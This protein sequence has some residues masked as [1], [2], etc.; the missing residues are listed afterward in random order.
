[1]A[2]RTGALPDA[3]GEAA[4]APVSAQDQAAIAA[5]LVAAERRTAERWAKAL[6]RDR[7]AE[8]AAWRDLVWA[9]RRIGAQEARAALRGVVQ[10]GDAA[11]PA[12]IRR[13]A[14]RALGAL[15]ALGAPG[16]QPEEASAE[17]EALTAALKDLDP[18][19]RRAAA[20]SLAALS[21]TRAARTAVAIQP[22]DPVAF[23]P[24][25]A[26]ATPAIRAELAAS[27]PG[28][29]LALPTMLAAHETAP[30]LALARDAKDTQTRLDAIAALGR[31]DDQDALSLLASLAFDKKAVD[32][33]MRKA[34]YRAYRRA[35][36]R[37]EKAEKARAR[38]QQGAGAEAGGTEM[39]THGANA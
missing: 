20:A 2:S 13:E 27:E 15:G 10:G 29:R 8:A 34:A 23:E 30:L 11:A 9:A 6:P 19:V 1:V 4:V 28:R 12:E 22:L 33:P 5:A 32:L 17:V 35:K 21:P 39:G 14:A 7:A 18:E 26:A 38:R 16:K 24:T 25:A 37:A 36:R 3:G 31:T